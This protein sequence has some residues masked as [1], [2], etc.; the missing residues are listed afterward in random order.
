MFRTADPKF[1]HAPV[2]G[3]Y[4]GHN[5]GR[6]PEEQEA[7]TE[8]WNNGEDILPQYAMAPQPGKRPEDMSISE[9]YDALSSR[10][11]RYSKSASITATPFDVNIKQGE[12][13]GVIVS[14]PASLEQE[15][16]DHY[17]LHEDAAK[18]IM[19]SLGNQ[20]VAI[21]RNIDIWPEFQGSGYGTKLLKK[22]EREAKSRGAVAV[23]L[24]AYP[25]EAGLAPD[26]LYQWYENHGYER[27]DDI[28]QTD[29][30]FMKS[31]DGPT[32]DQDWMG[33]PGDLTETPQFKAWFN[34]S[35]VVDDHGRPLRMFHGTPHGDMEKF[36]VGGGRRGGMESF[37]FHFGPSDAA[38]KRIMPTFE[39]SEWERNKYNW[40]V[41]P[42]YLS[43]K[44]PLRMGD[45]G[46]WENV[47]KV[48]MW[49]VRDGIIT[50]DEHEQV[51]EPVTHQAQI[52]ALKKML[53][54]KGYDGIVY[55]NDHEGGGDSWIAFNPTQIKSAIGNSGAFNPKDRRLTAGLW[56]KELTAN[57][58]FPTR[59][60]KKLWHVGTMDI[61]KK[62][63]GSHEGDGLSVSPNPEAWE[64]INPFTGGDHWELTKPGNLF[65]DFYRMNKAHK[66]ELTEWGVRQ[67]YVEAAG[68]WKYCYYD[69]EMEDTVCSEYPTLEQALSESGYDSLEEAKAEGI[70]IT[71]DSEGLIPTQKFNTRM[72]ENVEQAFTLDFLAMVYAEDM[73]KIDGVWWNET[74]DV[75]RYSAPRAVIFNAKIPSWKATKVKTA[76]TASGKVVDFSKDPEW[77]SLFYGKVTPEDMK[78]LRSFLYDNR[79]NPFQFVR[80]YHGTDASL[81]V[82]KD[83]LLPTSNKRRRSLQSANGYVYLSVFP[84]MAEDFGRMGNPGKKIEVYQV[85]VPVSMLKPDSDQLSNKRYWGEDQSIGSSLAESLVTGHG[86]RVKGKVPLWAITP[87]KGL[88]KTEESPQS[89]TMST[90]S[91]K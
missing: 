18:E 58:P 52:N 28:Y 53:Q 48:C 29:P 23:A 71:Q 40:T 63:K 62:R 66:Q 7:L 25:G 80:L 33:K 2:I 78:R 46:D 8:L 39:R 42:V 79:R 36:Q 49:L 14:D 84:G 64:Q 87:T 6:K 34:G 21:L 44:N 50:S 10:K 38:N 65:L 61:T 69:D 45:V 16:V 70:E 3:P 74:L 73:L 68:T 32:Q 72:G 5:M 30:V 91:E 85:D 31:A 15:F 59:S 47:N 76:K 35:K 55:K 27:V 90:I 43:I 12:A 24:M 1:L 20:R 67:G 83:G 82:M 89:F 75:S 4:N 26:Q 86:A 11:R 57:A 54:S 51:Q 56:I 88:G 41:M 19:E 9:L 77:H 17:G 60:F 37:G 22:F 81:P 13:R